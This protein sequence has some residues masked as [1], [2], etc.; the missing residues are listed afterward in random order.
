MS[1]N[2]QEKVARQRLSVLQLAEALGNVSVACRQRGMTRTQFYDYKR[3]FE[4]QG[5]EGLKDLPPIHK[6]HP[7]T[8]PP[9]VVEQILALSLTHPAWGCVRLSERLKLDGV[10]V[11]SPTIQSILI[12]HSMASK[13]DRL[14]K[15]QE[16][17]AVEPIEL[18]P[19][20]LVQLEKVNPCYRERHVESGRPGELLAQDTCFVGHCK[21]VGKVYLHTV[22]DT[23]GSYAFGFLHTSK[24]PEAAVA[25]LHNDALPFYEDR[26]LTVERVLTDNGR[27]F[28]GTETH[29]YELYLALRE[30]EH[31][32]TKVRHPQTNGFVAR[33]HRTVKEEFFEVAL[34]ETFYES[35]DALQADLDRWLVHYNTERPHLGYRN[36]GKRPIDTV[37]AYLSVTQEA[38]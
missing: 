9:A 10:S 27:E 34:R 20:Q 38:S 17:A 18:S 5:L 1:M 6:S 16:Q 22:V 29:P 7:Q 30:I 33:F 36:M 19:E 28:C 4:L 32:R 13:F 25:V 26:G 35:V 23:Y 2:A 31:R 21:G 12:K 24:V 14:L 11:S 8:T 37:N 15:L 3:R